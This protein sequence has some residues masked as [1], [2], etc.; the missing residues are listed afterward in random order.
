MLLLQYCKL[1]RQCDETAEELVSCVTVKATDCKYKD[2]DSKQNEQLVNGINDQAMIMKVI[3][4]LTAIKDASELTSEQVLALVKC[5]EE[6]RFQKVMLNSVKDNK[7]VYHDQQN[8]I[9]SRTRAIH[10]KA[11]RYTM[12]E[13]HTEVHILWNDTSAKAMPSI[14]QNIG[15]LWQD[16]PLTGEYKSATKEEGKQHQKKK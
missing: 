7:T 13:E 4:E 9:Q 2:K 11:D 5:T 15:Q 1:I 10:C 14:W 12:K 8:K 3:K 6:Q 16:E